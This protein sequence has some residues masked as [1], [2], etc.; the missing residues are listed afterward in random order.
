MFQQPLPPPLPAATAAVRPSAVLLLLPPAR[1]CSHNIALS[2]HAHAEWALSTRRSFPPCHHPSPRSEGKRPPGQ[3]PPSCVPAMFSGAT[4]QVR[5]FSLLL[6]EEGELYLTDY[7]AT[8]RWPPGVAG[9]WQRL[10][11]LPGQLR[12]CT[13]SLFF[14]P[15]DARV[16]IVRC[17]TAAAVGCDKVLEG[18]HRRPGCWRLAACSAG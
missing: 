10:P 17:A 8:A 16:P 13:R 5:R 18:A 2:C 3:L 6:L 9:N 15:D 14:E 4:Q 11:R 12:L 1:C 7:V